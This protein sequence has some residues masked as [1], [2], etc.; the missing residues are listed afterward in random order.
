LGCTDVT[1]FNFDVIATDD[2]GSCELFMYG[3]TDDESLNFDPVANTDDGSCIAVVEGCTD[4]TAF[5]YNSLA[6]TDDDSCIAV[7]FGCLDE[8]AINYNPEANEDDGSCIAIVEGCIDP[9]AFNYDSD[10]NTDDGSCVEFVYGCT[11]NLAFNYDS[12]SNTDDGSC[13]YAVFGCTD[14]TAT[15]YDPNANTDDGSCEYSGCTNPLA[16]NYDVLA[17]VDDGSCIIYGCIW[18]TWFVCPESYNP[19]A[20]VGDWSYCTFVWAGCASAAMQTPL[21]G[22]YPLLLL[23]DIVEDD[24]VDAYYH[25]GDEKI[26]CMDK[27]A[28]NYS[29]TAVLDN[30]SCTYPNIISNSK[31]DLEIKLYPQPAHS[32]IVV[33]ILGEIDKS[34]EILIKNIIGETLYVSSLDYSGKINLNIEDWKAGT[35]YLSIN[36]ENNKL[37]HRFVVE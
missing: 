5:N 1:A 15:N 35:Y 25:L 6:N 37:T 32:F 12:D 26:G 30:E 20:T 23:S 28:S 22:E 17:S 31:V 24:P 3:C 2:D 21:P 33:E 7:V 9:T 29:A 34:S 36:K 14:L 13:E 19:D 27:A 8:T 11:D 16:E 4:P 10:A 18:N